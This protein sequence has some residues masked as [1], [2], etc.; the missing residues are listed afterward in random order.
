[1]TVFKDLAVIILAA[2]KGTRMKSDLPKVL[3]PVA[4]KSMVTHVIACANKIVDAN[5]H[6]V[7]GYQA[8][9]VKDEIGPG[10]NVGFA[11]QKQLLGTGDAVK[12]ALPHIDPGVT[13]VMVLCGDVPLIQETT[14]TDLIQGY[15]AGRAA[16][17]VLAT[18]VKEPHGYG[19]IILGADGSLAGIREEA[20]ASD[21][22]RRIKL[23]NAGIYCFDM[24]FLKEAL[25]QLTPDNSQKE[26]YLTD[27]VAHARQIGARAGVV[28]TPDARQVIGVNTLEELARAGVLFE[29]IRSELA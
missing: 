16:V 2:G 24:G 27:T 6:V 3:H 10:A 15:D 28:I 18:Q 20:D 12:A 8:Q 9:R 4:G 23:V 13:R 7:I 11:L 17:T 29:Q 1:M 5:I 22:E 25:T 19:R 21:Q 26:Y 14:L